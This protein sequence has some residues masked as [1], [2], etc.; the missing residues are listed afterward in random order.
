VVRKLITGSAVA[1]VTVVIGTA[2]AVAGP[3]HPTVGRDPT[4]VP[5]EADVVGVG[6]DSIQLVFD[7]LS[8]DYNRSHTSSTHLYSWDAINP[9]TGATGDPIQTK[10][11]CTTPRPAGSS[12]GIT[13]LDANTKTSDGNHFCTDYAR[14]GRGRGPG[15]PPYAKGGVAFVTLAKDAITYATN[16][17]TNAPINLTLAQLTAIYNCTDTNWSQVGGKNAPIQPV[18]PPIGEDV[19]T[20]F[21][22][23]FH[24]TNP[25]SCVYVGPEENEGVN[26]AIMGNQNVIFPYSVGAYIAQRFHSAACSSKPFCFPNQQGRVC[27]PTGGQNLYGCNLNGNLRLNSIN[28]TKPTAGTP[29]NV[30]I[31][32]FFTSRFVFTVY[33]VVRWSATADHIPPYLEPIFGAKGYTCANATA[34]KDLR[35]Y[36]FMVLPSCGKTS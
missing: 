22:H 10:M 28:G 15:D 36:G 31:N 11:G 1:V 2:L 32:P 17:T 20:R 9:M 23:V 5:R 33:D 3:A 13:V 6:S 25:A 4:S 19:T 35:N 30:V 24:L 27:T 16:A 8:Y 18:L 29:P 21:L 14:S 34:K 7:Q 26:T 12:A